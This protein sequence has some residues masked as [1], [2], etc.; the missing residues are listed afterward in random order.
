MRTET[1]KRVQEGS[2]LSRRLKEL[3]SHQVG[4]LGPL[5]SFAAE[6][7]D[8]ARRQY[9]S[10]ATTVLRRVAQSLVDRL[11]QSVENGRWVSVKAAAAM[12]YRPEGTVR[13][14]CRRQLVKARKVG[15]R[16][17]EVDRDSILRRGSE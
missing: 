16:D 2:V 8:D 6:L 17:W 9:D 15:A 1:D 12:V 14:W 4:T 3:E 10:T 11:E 13:Y 7:E 5:L